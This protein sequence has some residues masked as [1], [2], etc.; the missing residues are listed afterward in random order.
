MEIIK[1]SRHQKIIGTF[2]ENLICNWLSRSGFEVAVV[3]HTGIDIIAYKKSPLF[4]VLDSIPSMNGEESMKD[5][6]ITDDI[7]M[8]MMWNN[9]IFSDL[10]VIGASVAE[11]QSVTYEPY[12]ED[13]DEAALPDAAD[14]LIDQFL[15]PRT[16]NSMEPS[17]EAKMR[18][19]NSLCKAAI[20][21]NLSRN[22]EF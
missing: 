2:G 21:R 20:N 15:R 6:S 17:K 19:I 8:S 12:E 14:F 3:D 16:S 10:P 4:K 5:T 13:E 7:I 1:S 18:S 9:P 11:E 22:L